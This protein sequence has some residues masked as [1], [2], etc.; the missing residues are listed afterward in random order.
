M[1]PPEI[2]NL[3]QR[4]A[5]LN[6]AAISD[7]LDSLGSPGG[8]PDIIS[9][10]PGTMCVGPAYTVQYKDLFLPGEPRGAANYID[11]VPSG[12]VLVVSNSG[13]TDC[14]VWGNIMTEFAHERGL[15]G[16]IVDGA[17]RDVRRIGE[18]GYPLFSRGI[19]MQSGKNR[20][21]LKATQVPLRISGVLINPGDVV[22]ADDNGCVVI[23]FAI[24]GETITRA[25]QIERT[26]RLILDAVA[27]GQ[28]LE[29]ARAR[30]RYD[31]PWLIK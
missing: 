13:R 22:A 28:T 30:Y 2:T 18:L 8:V 24:A 3:I 25:E 17:V 21:A 29:S 7:A 11:G 9:R 26:E 27:G 12:S 23:P 15:A 20:V 10:T 6:T 5:A 16:T 31:Q 19:Y 4:A 14:T 1:N